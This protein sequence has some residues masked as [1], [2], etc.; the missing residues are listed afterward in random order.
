MFKALLKK[1]FKET[2]I[3]Y[4][5]GA[6][7]KGSSKARRASSGIWMLGIWALILVSLGASFFMMCGALGDTIFA[8]DL[9][10]LYFAYV[11]ML[12]VV[13]GVVT[14]V[15]AVVSSIYNAKDN[16]LL[17]SMPI[18]PHMIVFV[19][20][21]SCWVVTFVMQLSVLVPAFIVYCRYYNLSAG[22]VLQW[23]VVSLA[24]SLVAL[25]LS[26]IFG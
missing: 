24:I 20:M 12:A 6:R 18:P 9:P 5:T 23:I 16:D 2:L 8:A 22:T 15:F 26:C 1:Q 3:T 17:L 7:S 11:T 10:W 19:R 13:M 25:T 14:S 21:L 4:T